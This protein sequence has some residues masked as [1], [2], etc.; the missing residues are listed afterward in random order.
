MFNVVFKVVEFDVIPIQTSVF[1]F[2]ALNILLT[3]DNM[4]IR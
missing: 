2:Q 1:L 3:N 4:I